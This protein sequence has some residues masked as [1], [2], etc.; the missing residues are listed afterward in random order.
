MMFVNGI[1]QASISPA[2]RGLNYGDGVFRTMTMHHGRVRNWALHYR[3]LASDCERL[4]I[5]CPAI[6]VLETDLARIAKADMACVVKIIVTRGVGGRGYGV[7]NQMQP[8]RIVSSSALP[9]HPPEYATEGI[10]A[11]LCAIRL[12][13]QP[14]LAGIKHLNRLEQVI[15]RNEWNDPAIAEGLLCDEA[16]HVIGGTMSNVF[17]IRDRQ[18][19]TPD[20]TGSGI[21]GVTRDR[22]LASASSLGLMATIAQLDLQELL[23]ADEVLLCNS[24][25]GVW[26]IRELHR[27]RWEKGLFTP[28]IRAGLEKE[29]D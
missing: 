9:V 4:G 15:A 14:L 5:V 22:I 28:L 6:D 21:A 18:L 7:F 13:R 3:K 27:K 16:G 1:E 17:I 24:V 8:G 12:A 29:D 11:R 19:Y 23:E 20:L 2:D 25:I 26:Q 10:V